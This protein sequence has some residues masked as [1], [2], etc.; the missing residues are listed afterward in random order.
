MLYYGAVLGVVDT[1]QGCHPSESSEG[2]DTPFIFPGTLYEGLQIGIAACVL[3]LSTNIFATL[4]VAYKAWY[5]L[6]HLV[7]VALLTKT[8]VRE[9]RRRLRDILLQKL[10]ALGWRNSSSFSSSPG[11][12]ILPFG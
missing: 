3:S 9:S 8:F 4:L 6:H 2:E 7:D 10:G 12:F 1:V 5:V 11:P